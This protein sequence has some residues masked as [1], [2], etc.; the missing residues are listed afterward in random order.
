[1]DERRSE[2]LR[3]TEAPFEDELRRALAIAPSPAFV[4]GVRTR[5]ADESRRSTIGVAVWAAAGL[6]LAAGIAI[7]VAVVRSG[8]SDVSPRLSP[9][10]VATSPSAP[11]IT[12]DRAPVRA[13]SNTAS[14][15]ATPS[16]ARPVRRAA[17]HER[18][19]QIA[20]PVV[21]ID[22]RERAGLRRLREMRSPASPA[23]ER[24]LAA[25]PFAAGPLEPAREL[26]VSP[27]SIDP[28]EAVG[29]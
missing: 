3:S 27:I 14:G 13:G 22:P 4:A 29:E 2:A 9:A 24:L 26:F 6:A 17:V 8:H 25:T 12:P 11:A 5:I 23:P 1:M 28:I 18:I 16:I 20:Q 7:G 19:N 15:T 10:T 21:L